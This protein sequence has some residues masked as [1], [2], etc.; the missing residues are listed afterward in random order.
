MASKQIKPGLTKS[1]GSSPA[2]TQKPLN[3]PQILSQEVLQALQESLKES[4][5]ESVKEA[6]DVQTCVMEDK[7]KEIT[8]E[9]VE[10]KEL[11]E[12]RN[13]DIRDY[14]CL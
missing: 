11:V 12:A 6:I 5:K 8:E 7:F 3:E 2:H 14:L 1:A 10:I 9:I 4:V 13:K